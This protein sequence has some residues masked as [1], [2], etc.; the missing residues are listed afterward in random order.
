MSALEARLLVRVADR[1]EVFVVE[2]EL[3]LESGVLVLFGPSGAGKSLTLQA[4]AGLVPVEQGLIRVGGETLLDTGRGID[5]PAH[6][7]SMGYVPQQNS[8]LPFCD[9]AMNVAFGLARRE[10]RH[11][12]PRV[13][14]LLEEFGIA[15]LARAR[16][17]S[18]SGGE[19]Q[20]VALA[21]AL[22]VEP[23]L[24]LLDEPFASID[25][26]GR[27]SLRETLRSTLA[28]HAMPAVFVTHDAEEAASLG[29]RVV[30]FERGRSVAS[31][32]PAELLPGGQPVLVRGTPRE[33]AKSIAPGRARLKLGDVV[34]EGPEA[35]LAP[36]S[37]EDL[38]LSLRVRG[39]AS[40][41]GDSGG[42]S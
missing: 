5:L 38:E 15:H 8:L 34:V 41:H 2:S 7:R 20:R 10:R 35:L 26:A 13:M 17:E 12:N 25:S 4:L 6:R 29:D 31:G 18:L 39:D 16:P 22:A 40:P 1:R 14:A 32:T 27:A 36:D 19:S 3:A 37:G 28:R 33:P 23:R 24:L 21:R 9:V 30:C 11:D 42:D